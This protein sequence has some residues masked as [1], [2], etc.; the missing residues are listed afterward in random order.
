MIDYK[1]EHEEAT[2]AR[3]AATG[4]LPLVCPQAPYETGRAAALR[5]RVEG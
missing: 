5:V 1:N 3:E 2:A 4:G